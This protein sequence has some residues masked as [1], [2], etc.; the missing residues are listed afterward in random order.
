MDE[1]LRYDNPNPILTANV[2]SRLWFCWLNPLFSQGY[3][4]RLEEAD[5]YN[6][7]PSDSSKTTGEK[8]QAAWDKELHQ[9]SPREKANFLRALYRAFGAYYMRLGLMVLCESLRLSNKSLSESSIG[10][11]VNLMSNDVAKFDQ[12]MMFPHYL[13]ISPLICVVAVVYLWYKLGPA[14]MAALSLVML[15]MPMHFLFGRLYSRHRQKTAVHTDKRMKVMS[16]IISGIRIIKLYC[17]EKPFGHLVEKL[18]RLE[19]RQLRRTRY[20]QACQM[21]PYYAASRISSFLFTLTYVLIG[22]EDE[23]RPGTVFMVVGVFQTLCFTCGIVIPMAAQSLAEM[24]VV[25]KRIQASFQPGF[26]S[27]F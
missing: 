18:R 14:A 22:R 20:V 24:L 2:L 4:G 1:T 26:S 27:Y 17:W 21:G 3:K 23:I 19:I 7:C 6:V 10:Q 5:M 11:I 9:P 16:E 25:I 8:L 15:L 12:A 13:W